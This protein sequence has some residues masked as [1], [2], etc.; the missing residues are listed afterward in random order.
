MMICRINTVQLTP[1][2]IF[3]DYKQTHVNTK[4]LQ[5]SKI[6]LDNKN[7]SERL[8]YPILKLNVSPSH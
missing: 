7:N 6:T 3:R 1:R 8:N 2:R 4:D 5:Q